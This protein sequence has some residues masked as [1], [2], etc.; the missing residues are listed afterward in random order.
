MIVVKTPHRVSF[1]GGG[2]DF[3]NHINID[4]SES[5]VYGMSVNLYSYIS[6][7]FPMVPVRDRFRISYSKTESA[8]NLSEL[9]HELARET[10]RYFDFND[11]IHI[12]SM[13]DVPASTGLGTSSSFTVGLI[14]LLITKLK[15]N[16]SS[17]KIAETAVHIERNLVGH[18]G[19]IQDQYW[20]ALG[21]TGYFNFKDEIVN[22]KQAPSMLNHSLRSYSFLCYLGGARSSSATLKNNLIN[23]SDNQD[24]IKKSITDNRNLLAN[25]AIDFDR[26]LSSKNKDQTNEYFEDMLIQSWRLKKASISVNNEIKKLLLELEKNKV[27]FKLCGAGGTGFLYFFIH[28]ENINNIIQITLKKFNLSLIKVLPEDKG[29]EVIYSD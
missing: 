26:N 10:L 1:F 16:M 13:S 28:N 2:S 20:A 25:Q 29:V 14:K 7:T 22:L 3:Q 4:A 21:G 24:Q 15:I 6:A 9:N 8:E 18:Q 5:G 17:K 12:S 19:G 23:S 27:P 11:Q